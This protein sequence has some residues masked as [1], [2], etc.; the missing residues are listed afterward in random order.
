MNWPPRAKVTVAPT[1]RMCAG[2]YI[3]FKYMNILCGRIAFPVAS[4]A[5]VVLPYVTVALLCIISISIYRRDAAM[6][7]VRRIM[8]EARK[9]GKIFTIHK[10]NFDAFS[11]LHLLLHAM[12][13]ELDVVWSL[14]MLIIIISPLTIASYSYSYS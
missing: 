8:E 10:L 1:W 9:K 12:L 2:E 11:V 5:L 3:V 7:S 13:R 4:N 6:M 14:R